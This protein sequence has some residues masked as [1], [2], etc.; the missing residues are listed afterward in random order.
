MTAAG[1]SNSTTDVAQGRSGD[2]TSHARVPSYVPPLMDVDSAPF[3]KG[4]SE[5]QLLIQRC[6]DCGRYRWPRRTICAAC[7]SRAS[8]DVVASGRATV[9]TWTGV[10]HPTV[11]TPP[12][13]LPYWVVVGALREEP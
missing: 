11:P 13:Q 2:V 1:D 3:W 6:G 8:D 9:C 5:Q 7:N 4:L 10:H 12:D